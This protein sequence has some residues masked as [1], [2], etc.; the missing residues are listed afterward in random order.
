MLDH[1]SGTAE[2]HGHVAKKKPL[3]TPCHRELC[4]RFAREHSNWTC[5]DFANVLWTDE[6]R[7]TLFQTDGPTFV[8][9]RHGETLHQDCVAPT[10]KYGGGGIMMWDAMSYNGTAFLTK[11]NGNLNGAGYINILENS[12]IPSAHLLGLVITSGSK[13]MVL[14]ATDQD[15]LLIGKLKTT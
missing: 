12:A 6:S 13:M 7:L 10:V 9:R 1:L 4:L 5:L 8:R 14:L 11:V 2:L 3:L 15:L